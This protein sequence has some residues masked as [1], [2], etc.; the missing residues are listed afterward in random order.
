P[1]LR[2]LTFG[3]FMFQHSIDAAATRTLSQRILQFSKFFSR[4]RSHD[5]HMS[6]LCIPHP[7]AQTNLR[8]LPLHKPAKADALHAAFYEVM[9]HHGASSV[10]EPSHPRNTLR[11]NKRGRA[12]RPCL[13]PFNV[14]TR[15]S[16]TR[17]PPYPRES[18]RPH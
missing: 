10:A 15:G 12:N 18:S 13:S 16:Y 6:I 1:K 7:P 8:R 9:A 2:A 5:L 11:K 17:L 3:Q 14:V 4:A